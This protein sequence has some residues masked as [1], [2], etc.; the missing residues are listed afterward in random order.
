MLRG[1]MAS[2]HVHMFVSVRPKRVI[3]DL[4]R[5]MKGGSSHIVQREFPTSEN[6]TGGAGS[7]V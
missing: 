2:D 1:V 4:V 3:S 7:E 5:N 6:A